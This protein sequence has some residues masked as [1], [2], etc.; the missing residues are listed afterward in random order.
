MGLVVLSDGCGETRS[1]CELARDII[2]DCD[3][4]LIR[5]GRPLDTSAKV[6]SA[7]QLALAQQPST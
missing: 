3:D 7:V 1:D 5:M 2:R 6:L 4:R